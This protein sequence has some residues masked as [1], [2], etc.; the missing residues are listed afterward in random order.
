VQIGSPRLLYLLCLMFAGFGVSGTAGVSHAQLA[1]PPGALP[2]GSMA[3]PRFL[4]PQYAAPPASWSYDP[5]TS[6]L[7]PCVNR[8]SS[9][10]PC[11]ELVAPSFG[12]PN[13]RAR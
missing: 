11:S 4:A 12:Q 7:T 9:D 8:E 1:G 5:Y 2:P 6:G 3:G 10:P 13:Y